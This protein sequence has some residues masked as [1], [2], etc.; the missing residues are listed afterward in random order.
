MCVC[1]QLLEEGQACSRLST[2]KS[3]K[4]R[5]REEG[6]E[7]KERK[8]RQERRKVSRQRGHEVSPASSGAPGTHDFPKPAFPILCAPAS[9]KA[10]TGFFVCLCFLKNLIF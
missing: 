6:K 8:G 9:Q 10:I 2:V 3:Q 4:G 1:P 5:R 7:R